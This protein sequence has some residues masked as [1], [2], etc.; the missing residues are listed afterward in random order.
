MPSR[1]SDRGRVMAKMLREN[2][3]VFRMAAEVVDPTPIS[4]ALAI[5]DDPTNPLNYLAAVPMLG[6]AVPFAKAIRKLKAGKKLGP[7]DLPDHNWRYDDTVTPEELRKDFAED[8]LT[9]IEYEDL[10]GQDLIDEVEG[11][12]KVDEDL[13]NAVGENMPD[14]MRNID[15][16]DM[17]ATTKSAPEL[18]SKTSGPT[19]DNTKLEA[20]MV[21][22]QLRDAPLRYQLEVMAD[23]REKNPVLWKVVSKVL[24]SRP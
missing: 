7:D 16:E 3:E 24:N 14:Y 9:D 4:D 11:L 21:L 18:P 22:E 1:R 15:A 8:F 5:K 12:R 17:A 13:Y 10:K 6:N 2:P 20:M 23:L 19:P